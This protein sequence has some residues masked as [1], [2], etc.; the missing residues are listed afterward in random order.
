[1]DPA[2]IINALYGDSPTGRLLIQHGRQVAAKALAVAARVSAL[3][4]DLDFI[5]EAA[6][7]HDIGIHWTRTPELGCFG[8]HP[9]VCHGYL[10]RVFLDRLGLPRH[11]LVSERHVGV[12]ISA[13]DIDERRLPMPARD[14]VPETLEEEIICFADKFFSKSGGQASDEKPM[15]QILANLARY[16]AERGDRF[17]AWAH[18]FGEPLTGVRPPAGWRP[19]MRS[20]PP[21]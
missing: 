17:L 5:A 4:P 12:G 6:L 9:Y 14:M 3:A 16:G 15:P 20:A 7:L 21:R 18:R 11:A 10:G 1:V 8:A 13:V 2:Q 19:A